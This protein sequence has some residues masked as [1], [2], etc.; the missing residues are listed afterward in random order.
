MEAIRESHRSRLERYRQRL[1]PRIGSARNGAMPA[2][3]R[4]V[5]QP[6]RQKLLRALGRGHALDRADAGV[7]FL[8]FSGV[9]WKGPPDMAGD[10]FG[11]D[12]DE[13]LSRTDDTRGMNPG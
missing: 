1:P 13:H 12:G 11:K 3:A 9:S 6:E 7:H 10:P 8:V 5:E 2:R 4:R